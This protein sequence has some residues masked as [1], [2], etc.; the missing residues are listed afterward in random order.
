[1]S[2][3]LVVAALAAIVALPCPA[4][5]CHNAV[6]WT[7]DDYVR[8]VMRAEK[9]LEAGRF[10]AAK[11]TIGRRRYP[12][13]ALQQRAEDVRA[14]L[15]L[16]MNDS[17]ALEAAAQRFAARSEKTPKDV[18]FRAWLA[19]AMLATGKRDEA[20]AILVELKERDLMPDAYAYLALAKL[21][22]GTER[23]E[24]W[25][26]CR[27]RAKN[28]SICELPARTVTATRK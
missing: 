13:A 15:A 8:V 1:M 21:S 16:R 28:K 9:Q 3:T 10:G 18:R 26:Q 6:Q 24:L 17:K 27:N 7:V 19:E 14:V 23:F 25:K 4:D 12:T 2:K 5:A 22:S 11:K 20:R